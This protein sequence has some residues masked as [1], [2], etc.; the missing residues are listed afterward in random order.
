MKATLSVINQMYA[1]AIIGPYAIGGA[2]GATFYLEPVATYDI[3]VFISLK[4]VPGSS[5][6]SLEP[7]YTY[8]KA[9]GCKPEKEYIIIEGWQVQFLPASDALDREALAEAIETS[10]E[11]IKTRVMT[12]EH[13]TAIALRTGRPKDK[14]RIT[15]F[16]ESGVLDE[17]KLNQILAGHGLLAKW[18]NFKHK[19]IDENE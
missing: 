7:I 15:Q 10:I 3:D 2:I 16:V 8:L 5:L 4:R 14:I 17:A 6:V 18:E 19:Y 1:D 13:L 9:R 12:A 11:D